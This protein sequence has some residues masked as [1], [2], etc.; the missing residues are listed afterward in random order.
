[1]RNP[2]MTKARIF[3]SHSAKEDAAKL[4][5][6]KIYSALD[7]KGFDVFLDKERLI[8]GMEWR[9]EIYSAALRAHGALL[10]LSESAANES[11]W[12]IAEAGVLAARRF[13]I[14]EKFPLMIVLVPPIEPA[15]LST[16]RF[17]PFSFGNVQAIRST[18]PGLID[19]LLEFFGPLQFAETPFDV[20]T[21]RIAEVLPNDQQTLETAAEKLGVHVTVANPKQT[22]LELAAALFH[23]GLDKAYKAL[24]ELAGPMSST[25]RQKVVDI[26][27]PFWVD[28]RAVVA[29]ART[30]LGDPPRKP[31]ALNAKKP[32]IAKF[33]VTRAAVEYPPSWLVLPVT[34]VAGDDL[35]GATVADIRAAYRA[36]DTAAEGND[37]DEIDT[38]IALR[39]KRHPVVI[40]LPSTVPVHIAQSIR[41]RYLDCTIL[42]LT[43]K[44]LSAAPDVIPLEPLLPPQR[45]L[46]LQA[47]WSAF[48]ALTGEK[49]K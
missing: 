17:E 37:D 27:A 28:A 48:C 22:S 34:G 2:A 24:K 26:I 20:L 14:R 43:G 15:A 35:E 11:D 30:A 25:D 49:L 4:L 40:V 18:E 33:Y 6:Q 45:E 31:L 39:T 32:L 41:A 19:S 46:E 42:L 9:D 10:L 36:I 3:I 7:A 29:L 38:L 5:L 16:K 44:T 1:M 23:C 12:V 47:N 8:E 21:R 13:A